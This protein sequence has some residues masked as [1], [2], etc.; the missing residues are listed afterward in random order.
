MC[1]FKCFDITEQDTNEIFRD[2]NFHFETVKEKSFHSSYGGKKNDINHQKVKVKLRWRLKYVENSYSWMN[3]LDCEQLNCWQQII[4][5]PKNTCLKLTIWWFESDHNNKSEFTKKKNV[6]TVQGGGR[7]IE[8]KRTPT[9]YFNLNLFM[10]VNPMFVLL[11]RFFPTFGFVNWTTWCF[12]LVVWS[13]WFFFILLCKKLRLMLMSGLLV[14]RV[15]KLDLLFIDYMKMRSQLVKPQ[16]KH[17]V[18][19]CFCV[20]FQY[21]YINYK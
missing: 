7:N 4:L 15:D 12:S 18:S 13:S 19:C 6:M 2:S 21:L 17:S 20:N 11:C 10:K 5:Y 8:E 14:F 16:W 1:L 3:S 9:S